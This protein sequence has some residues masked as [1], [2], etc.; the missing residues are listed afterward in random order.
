MTVELQ[1]Q[2]F[3]V[4]EFARSHGISRSTAYLQ[5]KMGRLRVAKVGRRTLVTVEAAAAWRRLID[6]AAEDLKAA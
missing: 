2:A 6:G 3:S 4:E 1:Q 5:I